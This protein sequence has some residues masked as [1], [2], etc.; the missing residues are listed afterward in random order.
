MSAP[1]GVVRESSLLRLHRPDERLAKGE[2]T[3]WFKRTGSD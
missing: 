2:L 1:V 3:A